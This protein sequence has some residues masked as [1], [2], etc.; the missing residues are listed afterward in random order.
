MDEIEKLLLNFDATLV[1]LSKK[2]YFGFF[3]QFAWMSWEDISQELRIRIINQYKVFDDKRNFNNWAYV[4]CI[5]HLKN[6]IKAQKAQKRGLGKCFNSEFD[7]EFN[8]RYV[9]DILGNKVEACGPQ[10]ANY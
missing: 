2:Y 7:Q 5:N 6:M 4:V 10:F 9:V 8:L 3:N 1:I